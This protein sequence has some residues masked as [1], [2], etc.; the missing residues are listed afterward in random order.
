MSTALKNKSQFVGHWIAWPFSS[1]NTRM[2]YDIRA[3]GQFEALVFRG[4]KVF[5]SATGDWDVVEESIQW[6]YSAC[7][8]M[9]RPR[10]PQL[11]KIL[12]AEENRFRVLEESGLGTEFWRG[13][14]CGESSANFDLEE[15]QP[16]L[17]NVSK[18]IES[19]FGAVELSAL[20]E[21]VKVIPVEKSSQL[22]FP[23][24]FQGVASPIYFS[25]FMDDVDAPDITI[26][27]PVDLIQKVDEVIR[28][29]N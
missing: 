9:P 5:A 6:T 20:M 13:M 7:K 12:S 23:I 24:V 11:N 18:L 21:R 14:K 27:A 29:M 8:G 10:R 25:V 16:F 22:I 17:K 19:G 2:E 1:D 4:E 28:N 3:G 26:S 15:V